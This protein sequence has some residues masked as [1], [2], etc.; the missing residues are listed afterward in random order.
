MQHKLFLENQDVDQEK[1]KTINVASV[2]QRSPFRYPGGKT[3]FVPTLRK[4]LKSKHKKPTLLIEPFAGGGIV[5]LTAI[6]EQLTERALMVEL[7]E[8]VAAVWQ[9]IVDGHA[10]WLINKILTFELN[11]QNLS[12][13]LNK[14]YCD[15]K[16][17]AFQTI[18]KNRTFHGGILARGSGII[19]YGENGK[20]ILSRWYP[21]TLARRLKEINFLKSRLDF[22]RADGMDIMR[23]NANKKDVV[24]FI[25]PPYTAGG[26]KAGA[27]LYKHYD[28]DHEQL[29]KLCRSLKGDFVLTYDNAEE[30]KSLVRKH[31]FEMKPISMKNTH[32]AEM[33][34][35][36]IGKDLS[37][38]QTLKH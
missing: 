30:V 18:L 33:T 32:H 29:F 11:K 27:R 20:G 26:K 6:F 7:D 34:E 12:V 1:T 5:S 35:L 16:N 10:D 8:Q 9:S 23:S 4:W 25:D 38:M 15:S 36:V 2:P 21:H 19:K 24:Y 17:I 3:W 37:W 28:V 13:E 14:K 31:A 22:V